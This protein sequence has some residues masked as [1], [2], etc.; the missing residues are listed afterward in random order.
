MR[1]LYTAIMIA[2]GT[3]TACLKPAIDDVAVGDYLC[4]EMTKDKATSW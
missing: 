3:H 1:V 4:A 2:A